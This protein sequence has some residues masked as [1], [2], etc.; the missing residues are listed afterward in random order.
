MDA[1]TLQKQARAV[2]NCALP[3]KQ[4]ELHLLVELRALERQRRGN[5]LLGR[6]LRLSARLSARSVHL[7]VNTRSARRSTLWGTLAVSAELTMAC[8][9]LPDMRGSGQ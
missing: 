4:I 5:A 3:H 9:M 2:R 8:P 1:S 7:G 6:C